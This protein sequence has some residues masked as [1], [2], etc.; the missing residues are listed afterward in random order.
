MWKVQ[1]I[2]IRWRI[3]CWNAVSTNT[4]WRQRQNQPQSV[5]T[6]FSFRW[7]RPNCTTIPGWI[8]SSRRGFNWPQIKWVCF[9]QKININPFV[10]SPFVHLHRIY[11]FPIRFVG[12]GSWAVTSHKRKLYNNFCSVELDQVR[13]KMQRRSSLISPWNQ[14]IEISCSTQ[15]AFFVAGLVYF[16]LL[17]LVQFVVNRRQ[18]SLDNINVLKTAPNIG[19]TSA[20][21]H[22]SAMRQRNRT[23]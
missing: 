6:T 15:P 4:V 7:K 21:A 9:S 12:V 5:S 2:G 11:A 19:A 1:F 13:L 23:K 3:I 18:T 20:S 8:S 14:W 16:V 17:V 10:V 22:S